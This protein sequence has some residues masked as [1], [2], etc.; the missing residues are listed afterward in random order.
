MTQIGSFIVA[1][2]AAFIP[3]AHASR[4]VPPVHLF[5]RLG[6]AALAPFAWEVPGVFV[7]KLQLLKHLGV[8]DEPRAEDLVR[9]L[10]LLQLPA[11]RWDFCRVHQ[12]ASRQ[13]TET[14][15]CVR[16]MW[17]SC[18]KALAAFVLAAAAAAACSC[19]PSSALGLD[20]L[21]AA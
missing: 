1:A 14:P 10:S 16:S 4:L 21:V 9:P 7:G 8:K 13:H 19:T 6:G 2:G 17:C 15:K 3:A 11:V 5:V 20:L 12:H 18:R